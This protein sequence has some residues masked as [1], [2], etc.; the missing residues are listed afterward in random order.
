[1]EGTGFF[2]SFFSFF[3]VRKE[4]VLECQSFH[5]CIVMVLIVQYVVIV[6]QTLDPVSLL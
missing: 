6:D 1:M 2:K 5:L 3:F 4:K